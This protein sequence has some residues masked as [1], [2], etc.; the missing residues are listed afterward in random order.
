MC[1]C[2]Y[3]VAFCQARQVATPLE[4]VRLT[5]LADRIQSNYEMG[6]NMIKAVCRNLDWAQIKIKASMEAGPQGTLS[7][8]VNDIHAQVLTTP[9][10]TSHITHQSPHT[11]HH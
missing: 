11:T 5:S 10:V 2:V 1:L 4:Q 9:H 6:L 8:S 7:M 3:V